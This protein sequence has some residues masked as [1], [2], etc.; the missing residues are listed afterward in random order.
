MTYNPQDHVNMF[1][2]HQARSELERERDRELARA[3]IARLGQSISSLVSSASTPAPTTPRVAAHKKP[4]RMPAPAS[5]EAGGAQSAPPSPAPSPSGSQPPVS[6]PAVS[7]SSRALPAAAPAATSEYGLAAGNEFVYVTDR[8]RMLA[9]MPLA[10][11]N[12]AASLSPSIKC[13][14]CGYVPPLK[15]QSRRFVC[16]CEAMVC[17]SCVS[18]CSE[19]GCGAFGLAVVSLSEHGGPLRPICMQ[20]EPGITEMDRGTRRAVRCGTRF[21]AE[22]VVLDTL[23][24]LVEFTAR[25][26]RPM[27]HEHVVS[28]KRP[29]GDDDTP[30]RRKRVLIDEEASD[31]R[32][33]LMPTSSK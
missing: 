19:P 22:M 30:V 24:S 18:T 32:P 25:G 6:V 23:E 11:R 15:G 14:H 8:S 16:T 26:L 7:A 3:N 29:L 13:E 27:C 2:A 5:V 12:I 31:G 33:R 28:P 20:H 9:A 4:A 21:C 10:Q 1:M 17:D